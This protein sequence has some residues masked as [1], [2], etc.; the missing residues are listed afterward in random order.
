MAS[1]SIFL[2]CFCS[3]IPQISIMSSCQ[4]KRRVDPDG[5]KNGGS[6]DTGSDNGDPPVQLKGKHKRKKNHVS[7]LHSDS[8]DVGTTR[9]HSSSRVNAAVNTNQVGLNN[10]ISLSSTK[11]VASSAGA[12]KASSSRSNSGRIPHPSFL[13]Y[14]AQVDIDFPSSSDDDL[15]SNLPP[16]ARARK[17]P[18][19]CCDK[20]NMSKLFCIYTYCLYVI[21]AWC[22]DSIE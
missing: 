8:V 10:R 17:T 14:Y 19:S 5:Q 20:K 4:S 7:L 15:I 6:S 9:I 22:C 13:L 18:S 16:M 11:N 12:S 2:C 3:I 1:T 21:T